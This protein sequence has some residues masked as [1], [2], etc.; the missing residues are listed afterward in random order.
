VGDVRRIAALGRA[1]M[2]WSGIPPAA[3]CRCTGRGHPCRAT[4]IA[5]LPATR[6]RSPRGRR[7]G[8]RRSGH[9]AK[10]T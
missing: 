9:V 3:V 5:P 4:S 1:R 7:A 6:R 8:R 10:R 2:S